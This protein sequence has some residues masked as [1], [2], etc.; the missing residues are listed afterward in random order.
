MLER[1]QKRLGFLNDVLMIPMF[2]EIIL[3]TGMALQNAETLEIFAATNLMFCSLFFAEWLI[4]LKLSPDRRAF[5]TD[6]GELLN[7]ISCIPF[8]YVFQGARLFRVLRVLRVFRLAIRARRYQGRGAQLLRVASLVGATIFAGAMALRIVEPQTTS[9]IFDALW[10]SLVTV[11]TVGYGDIA[12]VTGPGRV[13]ASVLIMFGVGVVGYIA[14][15]MT[16][17]LSDD[18]ETSELAELRA[19][20]ARLEADLRRLMAHVGVPAE[21]RATEG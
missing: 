13:V 12:P 16:S 7:L 1:V 9:D 14:G 8:N 19:S 4:A 21:E 6:P 15:F 18:D 20:N 17:V 2:T 10:W 11:S 3:D 5:L